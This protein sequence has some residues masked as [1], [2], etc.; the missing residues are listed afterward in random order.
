M[1][2]SVMPRLGLHKE[3][4]EVFTRSSKRPALARV[5]WIHLPE[6]CWTFAASCKHP[7]TALA[8]VLRS[9]IEPAFL[10]KTKL[11]VHSR[12]VSMVYDCSCIRGIFDV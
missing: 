7:I 11:S 8:L 5:F 9:Y 12:H 10:C 2:C 1:K 6:V 4:N 3:A